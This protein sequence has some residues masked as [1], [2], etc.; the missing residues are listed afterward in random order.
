MPRPGQEGPSLGDRESSHL[1]SPSRTEPGC[2][3]LP[4]FVHK[5]SCGGDNSLEPS[6]QQ[7][8]VGGFFDGRPLV[9]VLPRQ[10]MARAPALGLRGSASLRSGETPDGSRASHGPSWSTGTLTAT[11]KWRGRFGGSREGPCFSSH[12]AEGRGKPRQSRHPQPGGPSLP[13]A[14]TSPESLVP[15]AASSP[16]LLTNTN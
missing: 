13:R 15:L 1:H 9:S 5:Q 6:F 11:H 4:H 14:S 7:V 3:A 8:V 2:L 10:R 12:G 16:Y